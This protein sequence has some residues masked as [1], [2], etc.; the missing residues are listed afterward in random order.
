MTT[1]LELNVKQRLMRCTQPF[2]DTMLRS[3]KP[4]NKIL[5]M[6]FEKHRELQNKL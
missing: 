1:K 3:D 2:H 5:I 4:S 6:K